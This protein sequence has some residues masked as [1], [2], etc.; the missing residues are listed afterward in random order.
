MII[1]RNET[2]EDKHKRSENVDFLIEVVSSYG[3]I[4]DFVTYFQNQVNNHP[5]INKNKINL[6]TIHKAKGLEFEYV[7]LPRWNEGSMP[8]TRDFETNENQEELMK[9]MEEERR[10]AFVGLT[11]ARKSVWISYSEKN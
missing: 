3:H 7:F 6:M 8:N 5:E 9:Q 4:R 11:R 1:S 2:L 10:V